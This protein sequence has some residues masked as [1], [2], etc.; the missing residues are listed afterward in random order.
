MRVLKNMLDEGDLDDQLD[1]VTGLVAERKRSI[2][3]TVTV[4]P[5]E[6]T[7]H[8]DFRPGVPTDTTKITGLSALNVEAIDKTIGY[9]DDG[10]VTTTQT[11]ATFNMPPRDALRLVEHT[12]ASLPGRGHPK[13]SLHAVKR[14]IARQV[15]A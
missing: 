13:A 8:V 7:G 10:L 12:I 3:G 14:R 15:T 2:A 11:T 4:G 5:L 9:T 1:L 6:L